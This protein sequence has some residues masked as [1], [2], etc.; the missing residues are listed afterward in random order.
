MITVDPTLATP[1][2]TLDFYDRTGLIIHT[3]VFD[4]VP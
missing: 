1:R 2:T 3:I 4:A